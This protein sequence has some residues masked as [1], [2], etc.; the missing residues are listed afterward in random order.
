MNARKIP[1]TVITG[2]LGAGKTSVIRHLLEAAPERRLALIVNEFGDLGIDQSM[3]RGCARQGCE[4]DA[5]IELTNGCLCCT[6]ADDFLPAIESLLARDPPPE[7]LVIE[8]SGLALPKPLI[9][10]FNW[11]EIRNRL[12][13][14]GV[15][16]VV[17]GPALAAGRV[18]SEPAKPAAQRAADPALGHD[19]PIEEVFADQLACADLVLLNKA[20]ALSSEERAA[21]LSKLVA[22]VRPK[23]RVVPS[24]HARVPPD[25]LLGQSAAA[26]ADLAARPTLHDAMGGAHDHDDFDSFVLAVPPLAEAAPLLARLSKACDAHGILRAK[27]FLAITDKSRRCVVQ[28]V[29]PRI[30]RY[31]DR[32]WGQDE[33]RAGHLVVIG[34]RPLDRA[35]ITKALLG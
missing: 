32:A 27:G 5:I 29:G 6:V 17:D 34:L 33:R 31:F 2:F 21:M 28:A 11:P 24:E 35:A 23:V 4:T 22:L 9:T 15:I 14:D 3:L 26:E 20:D 25:L 18:A 16:A 1:A 8:T 13:V 7:H 10:A 12:T 19:N 30:E